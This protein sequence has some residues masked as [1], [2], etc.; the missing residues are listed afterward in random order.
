[1]SRYGFD[2]VSERAVWWSSLI[3][4]TD[5]LSETE[6]EPKSWMRPQSTSGNDWSIRR[7]LRSGFKRFPS[8]MWPWPR[9]IDPCGWSCPDKCQSTRAWYS[10]GWKNGPNAKDT[11]FAVAQLYFQLHWSP[12]RLSHTNQEIL[13]SPST[14]LSL[15]ALVKCHMF[16][17]WWSCVPIHEIKRSLLPESTRIIDHQGSS[18]SL[19]IWLIWR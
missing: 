5:Q 1:M 7:S 4:H 12:N 8:S 2:Q 17:L 3:L 18:E 13:R 6:P 10:L 9:F 19:W 15:V 16:A 14:Y 11:L